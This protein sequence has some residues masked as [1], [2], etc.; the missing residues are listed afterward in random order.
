M[1][2][3][4][5]FCTSGIR[6][7]KTLLT[8]LVCLGEWARRGGRG[9]RILGLVVLASLL[10]SCSSKPPR[11]PNNVCGIFD[12]KRGWMKQA[13]KAQ[14]RWGTPVH[15]SMAFVHRES[16]YVA[17]AKPPR[18]KLLGIVPWR[19]LSSAYGYAQATDEAWRDYVQD[20]N[21][22]FP[23]RDDFGD[24]MD[25]IGWYNHR[26][27]KTLGIA[28]NDAYHLYLAYYTGPTGYRKGVWKRSSTIQGYARKV[29]NQANRY[30]EQLRRC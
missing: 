10:W 7:L 12:E 15:I 14:R 13:K 11:Q 20:S 6:G 25:F 1:R 5:R 30:A 8:A 22:W 18:K 26:S 27:H 2:R 28:K 3:L 23:D 24:A 16:H 29:A 9:V 4:Q 19:R 21:R 17:D